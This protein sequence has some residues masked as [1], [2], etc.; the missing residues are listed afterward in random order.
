[1]RFA[2]DAHADTVQR[3]LDLD[4][5]FDDEAS[6]AEVSLARA[7]KG[8]LGGQIF[9]IWVDPVVFPGEAAWPRA[10]RLAGRLIAESER[11]PSVLGLAR[12]GVDVRALVE[13]GRFAALLGL[14]G[15]HALGA[16]ST[17]LEMKLDRL[18][19]LARRG[20]RYAA[21]TWTNSNDFAGSSGDDGRVRGLAAPGH[22]L[23]DRCDALGVLVDVSH[24]SDPTFDDLATRAK[25]AGRP[26]VASHSSARALAATPRN[27]TD[28]QLR[29][30]ADTG[31]V[32]SVNFCP[33]FLSDEFRA[34]A[35]KALGDPSVAL[36]EQQAKSATPD[37]G[38]A[39]LMAYLVR[40]RVA[41]A[42]PDPPGVGR[43]ADHVIHMIDV[44]G[45]DHVG[46][47]S[48]FD[49]ISSV[50]AGLEDSSRL[51]ALA[52]VLSHRGIPARIIDKVWSGNWLRV[53]DV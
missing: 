9:S 3:M 34:R 27:L 6:R 13:A 1:M 49:G 14:E 19:E 24:V 25:R 33:S 36:A 40:A 44:A 26:I 51:P 2:L 31:G 10:L 39:S 35:N 8:G 23:V 45:E 11:V 32:A 30:I 18:A 48:D 12:R 37:P 53:L 21:P 28:A 16:D 29:A 22:E 50:P 17:A 41:R 20:L 4:E 52:D 46:L 42:L 7:R 47:G 5:G 43:I 15:C 38:R